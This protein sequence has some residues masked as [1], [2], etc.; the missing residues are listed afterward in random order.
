MGLRSDER[1]NWSCCHIWGVDDARF[2]E[3]NSIVQDH[4]F[5]SCVANV[6]LL[7]TPL[8]AFTDT[9][10]EV[11]AMI[12]ICARNLYGWNCDHEGAK[13]AV[14]M[15]DAWDD[16]GAYPKSWPKTPGETLPPGVVRLN[17]RIEKAAE[18]RINA[19]RRDLA[20]AGSH[21]PRAQVRAALDYWKIAI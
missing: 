14:A 11:K 8:K 15:I 18:R 21:Y 17:A 6:L 1:P 20:D 16:W 19:V 10:P 4:K 5:F 3:A 7:P 12:R 9:M 2:Q 13:A